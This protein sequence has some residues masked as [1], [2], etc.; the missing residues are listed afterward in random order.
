MALT[1][2]V[3][4]IDSTNNIISF[5]DAVP[6][7]SGTPI[8]TQ[9][10]S[11]NYTVQTTDDTIINTSTAAAAITV[12]LPNAALVPNKVFNL[13]NANATAGGTV[14]ISPAVKQDNA[15]SVTSMA[16]SSR[17]AVKSDGTNY[18]IIP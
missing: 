11:A 3:V 1:Q 5:N 9:E 10:I 8:N 17:L 13:V 6:V 4:S 7:P 14:T 16:I 2:I 18:W 15:T 12:T